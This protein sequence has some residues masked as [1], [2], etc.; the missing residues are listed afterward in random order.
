M[1]NQE[2]C[3]YCTDD[4]YSNESFCEDFGNSGAGAEWIFDASMVDVAC[5]AANGQYFNGYVGGFQ[6]ELFGITVTGA[7]APADFVVSTSSTTVLGFSLTGATIS[8]GEEI[9]T[10]VSFSG[11]EGTDICFGIE[12]LNN[13][14]ADALGGQ[15]PTDWGDCYCAIEV[16]ECGVCV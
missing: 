3:G 14:I 9:L 15:A 11:F 5:E 7:T 16:D 13:V 1:I 8:P 12:V 4:L 10:Q 6:F 2:G